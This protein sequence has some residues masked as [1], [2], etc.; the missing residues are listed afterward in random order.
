MGIPLSPLLF[1]FISCSTASYKPPALLH[2][3]P[4][5][6]THLTWLSSPHGQVRDC[7]HPQECQDTYL[8]KSKP[9]LACHLLQQMPPRP[10]NKRSCAVPPGNTSPPGLSIFPFDSKQ[11][12]EQHR[13]GKLKH[14]T[15][16][17]IMA[18]R[19]IQV[20][21]QRLSK[22]GAEEVVYATELCM[23][24]KNTQPALLA[25]FLL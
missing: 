15:L 10:L 25:I 5:S 2:W 22:Q 4:G 1:A 8:N 12:S 11:A 13:K 9:R 14:R 20:Y 7:Q 17:N 21:V 18:M 6:C 3:D 19:G 16:P 23:H 24:F